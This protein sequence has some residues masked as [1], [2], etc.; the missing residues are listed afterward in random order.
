MGDQLFAGTSAERVDELAVL[1][2][3]ANAHGV[4][5][6]VNR[7]VRLGLVPQARDFGDNM[8][9]PGQ[10]EHPEMEVPVEAL[11]LLGRRLL[12]QGF[13][14]RV[15][16]RDRAV[17]FGRHGTNSAQQLGF[18]PAPE[19]AD[20]AVK[21]PTAVVIDH[22][23]PVVLLLVGHPVPAP[24]VGVDP[25]AVLVRP[26]IRRH[27]VRHPD[28]TV[29]RVTNPMAIGIERRGHVVGALRQ[30]RRWRSNDQRHRDAADRERGAGQQAERQAPEQRACHHFLF[31]VSERKSGSIDRK[32][33]RFGQAGAAY[34]G[35]SE[36]Q[37][38]CSAQSRRNLLR[39]NYKASMPASPASAMAVKRARTSGS[40]SK[41]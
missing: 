22:P 15:E 9:Q 2:D 6:A 17:L 41:P 40:S 16:F 25:M 36:W 38:N 33:G 29:R 13:H 11:P 8:R 14:P 10:P 39:C 32:C 18:A 26:P 23:A 3:D 5:G 24:I 4:L 34:R 7:A 28:F 12:D 20:A 27:A 21:G 35:Q 1:G 31:P 30:S 37:P 19:P